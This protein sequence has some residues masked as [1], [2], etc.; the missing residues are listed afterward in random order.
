MVLK[1][2]V[3][4]DRVVDLFLKDLLECDGDEE[5]AVKWA[6]IKA[7]P[8]NAVFFTP[9]QTTEAGQPK[10]PQTPPPGAPGAGRSHV[11]DWKQNE[12][13]KKSSD[14]EVRKQARKADLDYYKEHGVWP[15]IK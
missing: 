4:N 12:L 5:R 2:G 7:D 14:P 10:P 9:P 15:D 13:D 8:Q 1:D 3:V 11:K 6:E